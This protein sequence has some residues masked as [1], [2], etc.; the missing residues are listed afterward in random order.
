[1]RRS[2]SCSDRS[3][4]VAGAV[5]GA[6]L[7]DHPRQRRSHPLASLLAQAPGAQTDN[8]S[9]GRLLLLPQ[10]QGEGGGHPPS[11]VSAFVLASVTKSPG[12]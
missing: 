11:S 5:F 10:A 8:G 1:M 12:R 2:W 7:P 4:D 6:A 9:W 3:C